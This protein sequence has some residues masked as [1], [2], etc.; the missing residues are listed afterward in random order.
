MHFYQFESGN[1]T[2]NERG[3]GEGCVTKAPSQ[4]ETTDIAS[5]CAS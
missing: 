3:Q 2:G 5:Q 4:N 1:M